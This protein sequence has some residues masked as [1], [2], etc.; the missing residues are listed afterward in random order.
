M[1]KGAYP[2]GHLVVVEAFG[3]HYDTHFLN[4]FGQLEAFVDALVLMAQHQNGGG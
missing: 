4:G 2:L 1:R 3:L